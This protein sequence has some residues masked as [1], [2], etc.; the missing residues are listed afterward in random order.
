MNNGIFNS[1]VLSRSQDFATVLQTDL[2][3][4]LVPPVE[5]ANVKVLAKAKC[6]V[7]RE[8]LVSSRFGK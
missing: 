7:A 8:E 1:P 2:T 3:Q 4:S 6:L 5:Q